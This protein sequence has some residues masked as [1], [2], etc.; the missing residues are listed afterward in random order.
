MATY[1]T[2]PE[3]S[4]GDSDT[5]VNPTA[6]NTL[7][8]NINA[9]GADLVDAR[10]DGQAFPG[11]DHEALQATDLDDIL[12]AIKHMLAHLSGETNWYDEPET[13]LADLYD[14]LVVLHAPYPS[15]I[16]TTSLRGAAADGNNTITVST[17]EVVASYVGRNYIEG[18]SEETSL[19]NTYI[20]VKFTIPDVFASF[21]TTNAI[22]IDY[23]TESGISINCHVDVYIY[24]AGVSGAEWVFSSTDNASTTWSTI[25]FDAIDIT[26]IMVPVAWFPGDVME[27]YIKLE[28]RNDY[29]ARIGKIAFN[30]E[31]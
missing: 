4:Q 2:N 12:Q 16:E 8:D 22:Q 27:I 6:W 26:D 9:I 15:Y 18:T 1:P 29:H 13:S 19:Q 23:I 21:D 30:F 25:D 3:L 11:D 24:K 14:R 7:I 10:G 20:A 5:E 28:S 17:G 31:A